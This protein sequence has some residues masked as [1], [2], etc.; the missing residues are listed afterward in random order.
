MPGKDVNVR[1]GQTVFV[2]FVA[3]ELWLGVQFDLTVQSDS[4]EEANKNE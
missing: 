3:I 2:R 4:I 1:G